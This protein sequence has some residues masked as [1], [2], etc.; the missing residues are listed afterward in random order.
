MSRL[1]TKFEKLVPIHVRTADIIYQIL[2][3]VQATR[4][5]TGTASFKLEGL[6]SATYHY[7]DTPG[8]EVEADESG[9]YVTGTVSI[10]GP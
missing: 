2:G 5:V 1:V 3:T 7:D 8:D 10:V 4:T 6:V 9:R